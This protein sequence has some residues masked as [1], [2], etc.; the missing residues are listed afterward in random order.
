MNEFSKH[1]YKYR[2]LRYPIFIKGIRTLLFFLVLVVWVGCFHI[3]KVP[4]RTDNDYFQ[5]KEN[6]DDFSITFLEIDN[7][8]SILSDYKQIYL[9][10]SWCA[11]CYSYLA[12]YSKEDGGTALVS[13]NYNVE[14]LEKNFHENI[15]II[16]ILSNAC[17]GSD[18]KDKI[19]KFTSMLIDTTAT[20]TGVP[21]V[22]DRLS[23]NKFQR[24]Q[25]R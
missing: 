25:L 8:L 20:V 12:N 9:F 4:T 11:P 2:I 18:E 13:I 22:F 16:Y 1:F 10:A 24:V 21:Q 14:F 17:Y 3:I 19:L 15:D 5:Q 23:D 6:F 7:D